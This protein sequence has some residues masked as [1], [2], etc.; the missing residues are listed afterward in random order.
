MTVDPTELAN[1][2]LDAQVEFILGELTG[3]RLAEVVARD[4]D[5]LLG[6]AGTT[7]LDDLVDRE[8]VKATANTILDKPAGSA[9]IDPMVTGIADA[10]YRHAA[11]DEHQ[12]GEVVE[13]EHVEAL[14]TKVLGMRS[15]HEEV[16][17]RI[18]DSPVVATVASWFVTKLV[19]DVMQQNR[20]FA[21]RVPGVASL[22]SA[23]ERATSKVRGATSRHLDQL[24]GDMAGRGTQ[25]AL[26]RVSGAIRHTVD[27]A[28]LQEAAME[29]W[30]LHAE[31]TV[32]GLRDYL[33][34][35]DLLELAGIGSEIWAILRD[36]EYFRTMIAAGVDVFFDTYGGYT[37]AE[38]LGELGLGRDDLVT[39]V[40][41]YAPAVVDA[42]NADGQLAELVRRRL[43][44]FFR[45]ETV[46]GMLAGTR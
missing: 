43:E 42:L 3:D 29:V 45:S 35:E 21:E 6:V 28:P 14:V 24:L 32:S 10:V 12:L 13:R 36:T 31:D 27:E 39:E 16:L 8:R 4:V 9:V 11:N 22:L 20:E 23:G 2:L 1:R 15:L 46:L 33:S 44:P 19:A 26:R 37:V 41:R 5:D 18:G 30:D 25:L 34:R 7:A 40:Q 38:L 17:R